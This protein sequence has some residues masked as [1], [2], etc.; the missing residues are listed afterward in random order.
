MKDNFLYDCLL[1]Y[2]EKETTEK[3]NN[4]S[5]IGWFSRFVRAM[6]M[7][8]LITYTDFY[9]IYKLYESYIF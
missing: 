6:M 7:C 5:I 2:I 1:V 4:R 3:F 9:V 8:I